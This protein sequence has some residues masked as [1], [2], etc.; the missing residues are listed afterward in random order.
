M[1]K[2]LLWE[3][4]RGMAFQEHEIHH[5]V[6]VAKDWSVALERIFHDYDAFA[7]PSA[8][9]WPFPVDWPYPQQ[10]NDKTMDTYHRWME[11]VVPV[12]LGGLPCVT[13]PAGFREGSGLPMGV[14]L[15]GRRGSDSF[16]LELADLYHQST[17]WP[18]KRPP[19]C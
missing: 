9:V 13:L 12:S 16:L 7:L 19:K 15:A 6:N 17:N 10:I 3:I 18:S 11:V 2:E 14:Q 4:Q 5:A 8:Q 1:R